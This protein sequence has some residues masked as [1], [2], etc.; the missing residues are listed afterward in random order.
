MTGGTTVLTTNK[1]P[2]EVVYPTSDGKPMAESDLHR[3]VMVESIETLKRHFAGQRVY[4]SGNILL[5][6]RP[7]DKHR[8]VVPDVLVVRELEPCLRDNYLLWQEGRAPNIVIEITSRTTR[9]EDLKKKQKIYQD[10]VKVEEFFLFDPRA[11]YLKP[12]LQ[13]YRLDRGRYVPI[14]P[15][16]ER[17]PSKELGLYLEADGHQLRFYD[18]GSGRWLPTT[19]ESLC[20]MAAALQQKDSALQQVKAEV[21]RLRR[22][23][24]ALRGEQ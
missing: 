19:E 11:E 21:E 7:G 24:A 9:H 15:D 17:L 10:E 5:F 20:E 13:G 4:V 8:Y 3:N 12:R 14:L 1:S 22:E 16:G 2:T 18:P 6:Y 23:L